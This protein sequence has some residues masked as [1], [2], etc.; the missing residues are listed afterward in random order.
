MATIKD[1]N[2]GMRFK[3]GQVW[4]VNE[5]ENVTYAKLQAH[6]ETICKTRPYVIMSSDD[7]CARGEHI[8]Q[9]Y[10]LTSNL[11]NRDGGLIIKI[12]DQNGFIKDSL[13]LV[14]QL[15]PIE[16]KNIFGY[17][18]TV[19]PKTLERI[20][21][22]TMSRIL[23]KDRVAELEKEVK[24][25]R[26]K[27]DA[28]YKTSQPTCQQPVEED[29]TDEQVGVDDIVAPALVTTTETH[30]EPVVVKE[31]P[32]AQ[33]SV[34]EEPDTQVAEEP[35]DV[36]T[37][38]EESKPSTTKKTPANKKEKGPIDV[39]HILLVYGRS[40]NHP[41]LAPFRNKSL[42]RIKID[43]SKY[44]LIFQHALENGALN[45]EQVSACDKWIF[46]RTGEHVVARPYRIW[47]VGAMK[48]FLHD[49]ETMSRSEV[50]LKW[51]YEQCRLSGRAYYIK[52]KLG[53][54]GIIGI[55]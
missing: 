43:A 16:T 29:G 17:I 51:G 13:V 35:H 55:I 6:V 22:I 30:H 36:P 27:L 45:I 9:G 47:S 39:Q 12:P 46:E 3:R 42:G 26:R 41:V 37:V 8:V 50:S 32:K 44:A 54:L 24:D 38:P 20:D 21:R 48:E 31:E 52:K 5:S 40:V 23:D 10:P 14:N 33:I 19:A 15:T 18:S 7:I 49:Y 2:V 25:L 53:E 28:Q 1:Y 4:M 34:T 11:D